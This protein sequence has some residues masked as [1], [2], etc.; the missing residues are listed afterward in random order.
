[1]IPSIADVAGRTPQAVAGPAPSVHDRR[2]V[3]QAVAQLNGS[4]FLRAEHELSVSVD[5]R[6]RQLVIRVLD[7]QTK[8]ILQQFPSEQL[9]HVAAALAEYGQH[10]P[11]AVAGLSTYA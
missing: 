1:M 5:P 8:E 9:L 6:T 2:A 7:R 11:G 4:E 3:V 10:N